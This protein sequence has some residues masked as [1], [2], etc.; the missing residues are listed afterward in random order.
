MSDRDAVQPFGNRLSTLSIQCTGEMCMLTNVG[1]VVCFKPGG[2]AKEPELPDGAAADIDDNALALK[3]NTTT[4]T[5][6]NHNFPTRESSEHAI[7]TSAADTTSPVT[8]TK[9]IDSP[10][11][12]TFTDALEALD[13]CRDLVA[14]ALS[15]ARRNARRYSTRRRGCVFNLNRSNSGSGRMTLFPE[16]VE[17]AWQK[18]LEDKMGTSGGAEVKDAGGETVK[19]SVVQEAREDVKGKGK[20]KEEL[21][22]KGKEVENKKDVLYEDEGDETESDAFEGYK[23]DTWGNGVIAL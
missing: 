18:E 11:T 23:R 17:E 1:T 5:I 21:K 3:A 10:T 16:G 22:W 4:T 19:E 2:T 6:S 9:P 14:P 13:E 8:A 20:K 15:P 12:D 7:I